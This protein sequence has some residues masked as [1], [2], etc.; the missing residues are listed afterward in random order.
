MQD[1]FLPDGRGILAPLAGVLMRC[2]RHAVGS[3]VLGGEDPRGGAP[4]HIDLM[5]DPAHPHG[6]THPAVEYQGKTSLLM[7]THGGKV[8]H[9]CVSAVSGY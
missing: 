8:Q 2:E 3:S 7:I 6:E 5:C 4:Q 1:D 9:R